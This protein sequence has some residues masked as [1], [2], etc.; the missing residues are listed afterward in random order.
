MSVLKASIAS[1]LACKA[2]KQLE[3]FN[4][5]V[6]AKAKAEGTSMLVL[7]KTD[8]TLQDYRN[9]LAEFREVCCISAM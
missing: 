3:E 5:D 9:A 2:R 8:E 4:K 7:L 1:D 6:I